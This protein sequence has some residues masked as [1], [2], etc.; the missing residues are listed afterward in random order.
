MRPG[1]ALA[2]LRRA[3]VAWWRAPRFAHVDRRRVAV[4]AAYLAA[5]L[6]AWLCFYALSPRIPHTWR[7]AVD[8]VTLPRLE[9]RI[10]GRYYGTAMEPR[11]ALVYLAAAPYSL[12][13]A[14]PFVVFGAA[15]AAHARA[16]HPGARPLS[17]ASALVTTSFV[18]H[19][20]QIAVPTAPPWYN[21]AEGN[22]PASYARHGDAGRLAMIDEAT[23]S[24]YFH[25]MYYA[26]PITFG[27][28]PSMHTGWPLL[29]L[30]H[31][32]T[33][34]GRVVSLVHVVWI[35]WSAL[36][37]QHHFLLDLVGAY[38][39]VLF[40]VWLSRLHWL[41][42]GHFFGG[43]G[44]FFALVDARTDAD[45]E[46]EEGADADAGASAREAREREHAD[47]L[48]AAAAL[49]L[50]R[51]ATPVSAPDVARPSMGARARARWA[52]DLG[53]GAP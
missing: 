45:A 10:F 33:V 25:S 36:Y 23:N 44:G 34:G 24:T 21:R 4:H 12:H 20:W 43:D 51:G 16:P 48:E 31:Q 32:W 13:F 49:L 22:A 14:V 8:T 42:L 27:S 11:L 47:F 37:L 39:F 1:R 19:A 18:M 17:F 29:V 41:V 50:L 9:E 6:A 15:V 40:G 52:P 53:D 26:N 5:W 38:V 2:T 28:F 35:G 7:P 3:L 46:S 30:M